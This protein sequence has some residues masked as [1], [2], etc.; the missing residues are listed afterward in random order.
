MNNMEYRRQL[1][2][3]LTRFEEE[4]LRA[5]ARSVGLHASSDEVFWRGWHKAR[6]ACEGVPRVK[7]PCLF[8]STDW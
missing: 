2:G 8:A 6:T 7:F 5:H 1:I 4:E 3:V